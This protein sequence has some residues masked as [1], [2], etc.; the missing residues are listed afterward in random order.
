MAESGSEVPRSRAKAAE[1]TWGA[2]AFGVSCHRGLGAGLL[3]QGRWPRPRRADAGLWRWQDVRSLESWGPARVGPGV[4]PPQICF[5]SSLETPHL[6]LKGNGGLFWPPR[7]AGAQKSEIRG[8]CAEGGC[9][10][11]PKGP[12]GRH[13]QECL[14]SHSS[15]LEGERRLVMALAFGFR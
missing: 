12:L 5:I 11:P 1:L 6:P 9:S 4:G 15:H 10:S 8:R 2:G 13:R 14:E 3:L 7:L